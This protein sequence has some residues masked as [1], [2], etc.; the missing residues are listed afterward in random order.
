[1]RKFF[2]FIYISFLLFTGVNAYAEVEIYCP[3]CKEHIYTYKGDKIEEGYSPRNEDFTPDPSIYNEMICPNC[4]A[5]FEG[6]D[7]SCWKKGMA[8]PK[9]YYPAYTFLT[10]NEK[11]E[12]YWTPFDIN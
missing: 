4:G 11:G 1:M 8:I 7:Y 9:K 12:F 10:K 5:Y 3:E 6:Y 2:I